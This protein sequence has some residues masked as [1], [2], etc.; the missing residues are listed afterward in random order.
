MPFDAT[1]ATSPVIERLRAGRDLIDER[2]LARGKIEDDQGRL[3]IVGGI[4][5]QSR[6]DEEDMT[7]ALAYLA[8]AIPADL[9]AIA[10]WSDSAGRTKAD[11]IA[12]Y[13][14]AIDLAI[15]DALVM[16]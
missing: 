13:D 5:R 1:P 4:T 16:E 11:V 14:R 7:L 2:G 6:I 9:L 8:K 3:C 15:A 12:I 10:A